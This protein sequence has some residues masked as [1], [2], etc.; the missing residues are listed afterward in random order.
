MELNNINENRNIIQ[1]IEKNSIAEELGVE[2]GDILLSIN[3]EKVKD[4]IDYKYLIADEYIVVEIEKRN[5]EIWELEIEKEYSEDIGIV[6]T[7]PLIDKARSCKN[8][9][10]FCFIDQLPKGM[11][12]TLYFKDDDSRLSFLQGN[13]VTLT[14]M[15][16]DEINRIVRYRLSPINISVHTT[17]PDLR[18]KMLRNKNAGKIYGILKKFSEAG[19]EMNCQIVLVPGVNDGEHLK[20]TLDD[21]F[22]LY[23]NIKSTAVVPIGITKFREGLSKVSCYD[24]ESAKNV[25]KIVEEKQEY[26]LKEKNIR[27]IFASDEFFVLSEQEI[28]KSDEYEGFPQIENGVGLIRV[29]ND[30]VDKELATVDE[31]RVNN[32]SYLLVTGTLAYDFMNKITKKISERIEG[33]RLKVVAITNNY[34]GETITVSGLVT[35]TDIV[36]QLEDCHEYDGVIIPRSMLKSNENILLDDLTVKDLE[37]KLNTKIIISDVDGKSFVNIF[38]NN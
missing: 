38:N 37:K 7:N 11:R 20:R 13:F 19:I 1:N 4:I 5:E 28:P 12:E 34:F 2:T 22:D 6:F 25:I 23:P 3:G 27:F 33:L 26:Y 9:C 10:M 14:N 21:L 24:K 17:E 31:G 29:F 8:K 15:S 16:D 36:D 32:N 30:E 35:G 18:V